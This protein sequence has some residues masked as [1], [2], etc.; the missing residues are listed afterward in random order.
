MKVKEFNNVILTFNDDNE[1]TFNKIFNHFYPG[2]LFFSHKLTGSKEEAEDISLRVFQKLFERWHFFETETQIK[3]FLY[4]S[5]KNSCLNYLKARK[6]HRQKLS[7]YARQISS[8]FSH[9]EYEII[10]ELLDTVNT[11]IKKLPEKRRQIFKLIYIDEL[12][13]AE[14]AIQLSITERTIYNQASQAMKTLRLELT[15][16]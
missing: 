12:K 2:L 16:C 8:S 11:V 14:V 10:N 7:E 9:Y 1:Q 3:G 13:P 15:A 5:A 4:I 6:Q